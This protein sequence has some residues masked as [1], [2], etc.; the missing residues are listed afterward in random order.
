[1]ITE[2]IQAAGFPHG[3]KDGYELGC[4]G[5]V[6]VGVEA[7]GLSCR[8]AKI[9]YSGDYVY[10]RRVQSGMTPAEI[11][12][13]EEADVAAARANVLAARLAVRAETRNATR[14]AARAVTSREP[15]L[16]PVPKPKAEKTPSAVK[17][18]KAA[19]ATKPERVAREPKVKQPK[20]DHEPVHGTIHGYV[21]GC[22]ADSV[23]PNVEAGGP[24]CT[25]A[26]RTYFREYRRRRASGEGVA[27]THG[28]PTGYALGCR[29]RTECPAPDGVSCSEARRLAEQGRARKAGVK[30][31]KTVQHGT[32]GGYKKL[33]CR[34][35]MDCPAT[36]DGSPS[37][38]EVSSAY[39]AGVRQRA[40]E[41]AAV[42]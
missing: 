41:R 9:R 37:C 23:C 26:K 36:A 7:F 33:G 39:Q 27:I 4:R 17:A 12:A 2:D 3:S 13:A 35:G 31:R 22:K 32:R 1:M 5:G 28:I 14:R 8:D 16:T 42:S 34:P 15:K 18:P 11:V 21:R 29:S 40:A 24:S 6:C 20:A 30:P 25:E 38:S 10:L 19:N